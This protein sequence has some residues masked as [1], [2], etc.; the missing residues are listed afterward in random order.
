MDVVHSYTLEKA[1]DRGA[2][3][4]IR[5]GRCRIRTMALRKIKVL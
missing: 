5:A 1:D 4:R 3:E 2:A